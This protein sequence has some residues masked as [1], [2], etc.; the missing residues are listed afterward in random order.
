MIL[1]IDQFLE[2]IDCPELCNNDA[3]TLIDK[4]A[5]PDAETYAYYLAYGDPE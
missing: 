4:D 5:T 1:T 2:D 3:F